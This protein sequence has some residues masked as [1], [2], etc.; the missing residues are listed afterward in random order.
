VPLCSGL[1]RAAIRYVHRKCGL[2]SNERFVAGKVSIAMVA[3]VLNG[4]KFGAP[5]AKSVAMLF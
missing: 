5:W 3:M 2:V 4:E 1:I